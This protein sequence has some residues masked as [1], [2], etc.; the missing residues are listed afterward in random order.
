MSTTIRPIV[1]IASLWLV[2]ALPRLAIAECDPPTFEGRPQL[3]QIRDQLKDD[4]FGPAYDVFME[5]L[6]ES[7]DKGDDLFRRMT[8]WRTNECLPAQQEVQQ[9]VAAESAYKTSECGAKEAPKDVVE[10]CRKRLGELQ[11]WRGRMET[12]VAQVNAKRDALMAES[13][14]LLSL[15]NRAIGNAQNL[16]N[17]D[18]TEQAFRLFIF[19]AVELDKGQPS[20]DRNSCRTFADIATALGK[21]VQNQDIF[22]DLLVRNVVERRFDVN[23]FTGNPPLTPVVRW[24]QEFG[25]NVQAFNAKG[26]KQTFYDNISENQVRHVAGYMRSG[27]GFTGTAGQLVSW[28]SD[29]RIGEMADYRL[30]VEGAQ[31][32]WQLRRGRL[33]T[34]NFG[35]AIAD[36]LCE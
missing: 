31:M 22:I 5:D 30:A 36:R 28:F 25:R 34:A 35:Q 9:L 23:L 12:R 1:C 18:N 32:G 14:D 7:V 33:S 4:A 13:N 8:E 16:L 24:G 3:V 11:S 29:K 10:R 6:D 2:V 19:W 20:R 26:F 27:Y 17:P 21:R 15:V